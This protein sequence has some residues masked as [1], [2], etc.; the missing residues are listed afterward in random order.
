MNFINKL[1]PAVKIV[2][3]TIY[4]LILVALALLIISFKT[5]DETEGY[6][7]KAKDENIQMVVKM[8]ET[9]SRG[10]ES[11]SETASWY[12]TLQVAKHNPDVEV[13]NIE[14][15]IKAK[16]FGGSTIYFEESKLSDSSYKGTPCTSASVFMS[17][18][19]SASRAT[20]KKTTTSNSELKIVYVRALYN[21]TKGEKTEQKEL[22]YYFRPVKPENEDFSKYTIEKQLSQNN[23][24]E[25]VN[26]SENG[27]YNAAV[28]VRLYSDDTTSDRI[29]L[30]LSF[31][32]GKLNEEGKSINNAS[33]T[34]FAKVKNDPTD[35]E[36]VISDYITIADEHGVFIDENNLSAWTTTQINGLKSFYTSTQTIKA[37]YDVSE[38]YLLVTYTINNG[39]TTY[40]RIKINLPEISE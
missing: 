15:Y 36:N 21:V 34:L 25:E 4:T 22:K 5:E 9:R 3:V 6:G 1:S 7:T 12:T 31:N 17:S 26:A 23:L 30:Y 11:T 24:K 28:K 20:I 32:E 8:Y 19:S 29:E 14:V 13:D 39:T 18:G 35:T 38:L 33:V 40:D 10:S 27:Y 16:T 37:A 2:I